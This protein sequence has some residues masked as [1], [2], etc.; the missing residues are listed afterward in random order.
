[1]KKTIRT[2]EISWQEATRISIESRRVVSTEPTAHDEQ[3]EFETERS[4]LCEKRQESDDPIEKP[5]ELR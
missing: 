5:L 1:M 3:S 2:I 4:N